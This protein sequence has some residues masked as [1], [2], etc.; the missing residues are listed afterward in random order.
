MDKRESL[1]EQS[2]SKS[3]IRVGVMKALTIFGLFAGFLCSQS[4]VASSSSLDLQ[5]SSRPQSCI[6][7][8][9]D[10]RE[11]LQ[12]DVSTYLYFD[13]D[14]RP[15]KK[16]QLLASLREM[17]EA[18]DSCLYSKTPS[19]DAIDY[20]QLSANLGALVDMLDLPEEQMVPVIVKF[21]EEKFRLLVS[22]T[23][24]ILQ[25]KKI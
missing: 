1:P 22:L 4:S 16:K 19:K 14:D 9:R 3:Q 7:H 5:N 23:E 15:S 18:F 20:Y 12:G 13:D 25:A 24:Q 11:F 21:I 6:G 10:L 17:E 8:V 2:S